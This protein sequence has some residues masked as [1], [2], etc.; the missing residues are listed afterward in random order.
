MA[1]AKEKIIYHLNPV[2]KVAHSRTGKKRNKR[3]QFQNTLF[4]FRLHLI[5]NSINYIIK[6]ATQSGQKNDGTFLLLFT[7]NLCLILVF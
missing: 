7:L 1:A 5:I 2:D 3:K 4:I 6:N